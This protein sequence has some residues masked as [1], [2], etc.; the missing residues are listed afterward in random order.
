MRIRSCIPA[1]VA[2][3]VTLA[4]GSGLASAQAPGAA[5]TAATASTATVDV[6]TACKADIEALCPGVERG[7]RSCG[8]LVTHDARAQHGR[9]HGQRR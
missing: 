8:A 1:A 6:R 2:L 5:P 7:E 3:S 9:N 4:L